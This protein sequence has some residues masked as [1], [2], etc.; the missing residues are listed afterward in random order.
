MIRYLR[1]IAFVLVFFLSLTVVGCSST[2]PD[3]TVSHEYPDC[4][5]I[6]GF[7]FTADLVIYQTQ[8]GNIFSFH[9]IDDFFVGDLVAVIMNDAGTPEVKDD[10]VVNVRYVGWIDEACF[11]DWVKAVPVK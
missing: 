9:G 7:D 5:L 11:D 8:N 4:G 1:L 10:I 2:T 6:I 3:E